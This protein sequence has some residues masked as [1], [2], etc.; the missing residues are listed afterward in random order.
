MGDNRRFLYKTL[1][2]YECSDLSTPWK[3]NMCLKLDFLKYSAFDSDV[4][5]DFNHW[6]YRANILLF[7]NLRDLK[8]KIVLR[9]IIQNTILAILNTNILICVPEPRYKRI[10]LQQNRT[11]TI[12]FV[13]VEREARAAIFQSAEIL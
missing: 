8:S 9:K 12:F 5:L 4:K 13:L 2:K 7:C 6:R 3:L 10:Y 11:P 1:I